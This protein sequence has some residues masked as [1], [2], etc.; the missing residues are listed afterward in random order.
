MQARAKT[1]CRFVVV[2]APHFDIAFLCCHALLVRPMDEE[3]ANEIYRQ[4]AKQRLK[5]AR[6]MIDKQF[7][8][9]T[10]VVKDDVID[11]VKVEGVTD[12]VE[13]ERRA[14]QIWEEDC[15]TLEIYRTAHGKE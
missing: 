1:I 7:F 9:M 10:F 14:Q 11:M 5:K 13:V 15:F 12:G 8:T 3:G 2:W 6:Q 4:K